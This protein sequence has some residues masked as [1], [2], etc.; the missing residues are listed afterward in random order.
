MKNITDVVIK[1]FL[2]M[3]YKTI[4]NSFIHFYK[5]FASSHLRDKFLYIAI[6]QV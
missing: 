5:K 1:T 2:L 6:Y 4:T 3:L